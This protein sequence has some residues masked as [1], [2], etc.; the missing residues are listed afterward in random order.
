MRP[1]A[2]INGV[3][4][5]SAAALG[6]VLGVILCIRYVMTLDSSLDQTVVQSDLP[7]EELIRDMLIFAALAVLAGLTFWGQLTNRR[8]RWTAEYLLAVTIVAV[9]IIFLAAA[10]QRS[11]DLI[12]LAVVAAAGI[13]IWAAGWYSGAFRRIWAW[14]EEGG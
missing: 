11:R 2:F 5:A 7:L 3:I 10:D 1:I 6:G 12:C 9:L 13:V 4:F 14:L 8:W